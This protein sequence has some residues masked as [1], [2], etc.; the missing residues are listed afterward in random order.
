MMKFRTFVKHCSSCHP[1]M[2]YFSEISQWIPKVFNQAVTLL[3]NCC[4]LLHC[5]NKWTMDSLL[6]WQKVQSASFF[7]FHLLQKFVCDQYIVINTYL[8]PLQCWIFS[9]SK[10]EYVYNFPFILCYIINFVP[11]NL[12]SWTFICFIQNFIHNFWSVTMF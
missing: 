2:K 6:V 11:C 5:Q 7:Y 3:I 10:G 9:N 8:K 4:V 1:N 12:S